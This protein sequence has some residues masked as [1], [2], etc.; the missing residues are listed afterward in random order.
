MEEARFFHESWYRI[1][2]QRVSL[3]A[4]VRATRQLFR[5]SR[6]HVLSDPYSGQFFRLRPAAYDF[7]ARLTPT[8]TVGEVW[9][10]ALERDP[11][12]APG[13]DEVIQLLAQLYHSNLLHYQLP[14]DSEKLFERYKKRKSRETR[15]TLTNLMFLRIPLW[16]PD[17]FLKRALPFVRPLMGPLGVVAW[18]GMVL[19]ALLSLMP[20]SAELGAQSQGLL[21]LGNLPLLYAGMVLTKALHELGHAFAVR[22]FGGEVHTLG[23]MFLIFSPLPYVDAT[24]AWAFRSRWKRVFV[25]AAGMIVEVFVGA[26]SAFVWAGSGPG[27]IQA[28]AYN[29]MFVSSVSTLLFNINPLLRY[30]GYYILSDLLD[31]P[32][33]NAGAVG[34]LRHL[35]ERYAFG[36]LKSRSPAASRREKAW[37]TVYGLASGVYRVALFGGILL[38]LADRFMLAGIVMAIVCALSW[39]VAPAL[40]FVNYLVTD[41]RLHRLR[42]R[43]A[44]VCL[45]A[46]SLVLGLLLL[47]PFPDS[48]R[49]PG[50]VKAGASEYVANRVA[51]SVVRVLIPPGSRVRSGDPLVMLANEEL[52]FRLLEMEGK[53]AQVQALRQRSLR[54]SQADLKPVDSSI[55]AIEAQIERL[56]KD[57]AGLLVRA[58]IQGVWVSGSVEGLV[59]AWVRGGTTLGQV[60]DDRSFTFSSVVSQKEVS[61]LFSGEVRGA[62]VRLAGQTRYTISALRLLR[63][64]MERT[65]LPSAALAIAAGGEIATN[66]ADARGVDAAESFYEVRLDLDPSSGARPFHG[67]SGRARFELPPTPLLGQWWLQFRRFVQER[68]RI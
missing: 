31:I 35:V 65:E 1:A 30:D 11:E 3:S 12:N 42:L 53:L 60:V 55:A 45:G 54:E 6:W 63:I 64:P 46:A 57:E 41:P 24:A 39:V 58:P 47:V 59:G 7:V 4:G 67:Q 2:S 5:G 38:F 50:I 18:L 28:L 27:V 13:Q 15:A 61:R 48:W 8:R 34:H 26:C 9:K 20:R 32:N 62:E 29:M 49:S 36:Y 40:R 21:S 52:G 37:L 19:W 22:R 33:L 14:P 16:D 17:S 10:E 23:V 51:G 25:G 68:Y 43:A 66:Q 44:L 56:R